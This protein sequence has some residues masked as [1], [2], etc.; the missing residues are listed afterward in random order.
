MEMAR[1]GPRADRKGIEARAR[2]Q[3][4]VQKRRRE[5]V[6]EEDGLAAKTPIPGEPASSERRSTT[7]TFHEL[8]SSYTP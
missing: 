1:E 6:T 7:D 8:H 5:E 2:I 3:Q 4:G